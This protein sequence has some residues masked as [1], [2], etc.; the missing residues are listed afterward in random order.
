MTTVQ[1]L[2][3]LGDVLPMMVLGLRLAKW[4][5]AFDWNCTAQDDGQLYKK[6]DKEMILSLNVALLVYKTTSST[7]RLSNSSF[8]IP[9]KPRQMCSLITKSFLSHYANI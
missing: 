8:Y 5:Q 2:L 6:F 1:F 7:L 9:E 3:F 4:S